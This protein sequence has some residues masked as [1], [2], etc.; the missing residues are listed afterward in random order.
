MCRNAQKRPRL[1]PTASKTSNTPLQ[2]LPQTQTKLE[3]IPGLA[4]LFPLRSSSTHAPSNWGP[5]K[6]SGSCA[7]KTCAT[8]PFGHRSRPRLACHSGLRSGGED[9]KIPLSPK[10]ITSRTCA[11]VSPTS[12]IRAQ[13][14]ASRG[15][16]PSTQLRTHSA[17]ARVLPAPRP[18]MM[19]QL[20]QHPS[21]VI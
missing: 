14:P 13:R 17:P 7:E 9:A 15:P 1:P 4:R 11:T 10:I 2:S 5:R 18:P 16:A 19:I 3:H 20:R 6:A 21:G 12:A 8:A